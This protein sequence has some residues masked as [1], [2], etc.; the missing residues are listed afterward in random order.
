MAQLQPQLVLYFEQAGVLGIYFVT[1]AQGKYIEV[2]VLGKYIIPYEEEKEIMP[3]TM[4][5]DLLGLGSEYKIKFQLFITKLENTDEVHNILSFSVD[6]EVYGKNNSKLHY[7]D[8][9]PAVSIKDKKLIIQTAVNNNTNFET[10]VP[11]KVGKWMKIEI[12]QHVIKNKV[13]IRFQYH[14]SFILGFCS[15][16]ATLHCLQGR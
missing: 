6:R 2:Y 1:Y 10:K 16:S 5:T 3:K 11:L 13:G 7:G 9:N 14:P 4:I 12:C 8:R 15:Q